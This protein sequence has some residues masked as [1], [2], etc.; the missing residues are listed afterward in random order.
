MN[1]FLTKILIRYGLK[2]SKKDPCLFFVRKDD[3][4]I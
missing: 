1:K 2:H 3:K 4:F